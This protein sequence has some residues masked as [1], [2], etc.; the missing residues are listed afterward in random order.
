MKVLSAWLK[1]LGKPVHLI[2]STNWNDPPADLAKSFLPGGVFTTMRLDNA[3]GNMTPVSL[4]IHIG[5]LESSS[6]NLSL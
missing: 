5:R 3:D 6:H 1:Q 4:P 2:D